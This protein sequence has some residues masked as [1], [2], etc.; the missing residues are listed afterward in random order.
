MWAFSCWLCGVL[1]IKGDRVVGLPFLSLSRGEFSA[2]AGVEGELGARGMLREV[3][4]LWAVFIALVTLFTLIMLLPAMSG[5]LPVFPKPALSASTGIIAQPDR[6]VG[7][8]QMRQDTSVTASAPD[9]MAETVRASVLV[10]VSDVDLTQLAADQF[11]GEGAEITDA[12][13]A[14]QALRLL[15]Q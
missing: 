8:G 15:A 3:L 9:E 7:R 1:L 2:R 6:R 12:Q 10:R 13:A 14:R 5:P 4:Y 11:A